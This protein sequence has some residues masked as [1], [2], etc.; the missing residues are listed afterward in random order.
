MKRA[1]ALLLLLAFLLTGCSGQAST[2]QT[3]AAQPVTGTVFAMDTVM[4]LTIYGGEELLSAA[5]ACIGDLEAKLSVTAETSEI[6]TVN[7]NGGGTLSADTTDLLHRA[8]ELCGRTNGAL[9]LSIYPVVRAWGFTTGEYRVPDDAELNALL[10]HVDYTQIALDE[11]NGQVSLASAM[12]IDLGSVAKG[13]T[14]D[15]LISLLRESGVTSAL[16]NLGGNV[17]ALG[18][19][20]DG[21]P[22]RIAVRDPFGD[23]YVGILEITDQAVV[24]S[25]GYERYFVENGQTYWHILDPATGA[26]VRSGLASVTVVGDSGLVCD[27]LSTALFVMGLEDAADFWRGSDDF[28]AILVTEGGQVYITEGLEDVFSLPE[29]S[30]LE[31]VTVIRRG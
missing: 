28:E 26:P 29:D 11:E 13:Y 20:P 3:A 15:R 31:G 21:S 10:P 25:G 23:G 8:L 14:G 30:S 4:D 2:E 5:Q 9:D 24:T 18:S 16:L 7:Q 6:Y 19:K 22:W 12:E 27:G 1:F 17:Q